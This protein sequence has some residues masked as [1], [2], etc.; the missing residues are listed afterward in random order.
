[1]KSPYFPD[2]QSLT[3]GSDSSIR[4][5]S[6]VPGRTNF[7]LA[8]LKADVTLVYSGSGGLFTVPAVQVGAGQ[9]VHKGDISYYV[10]KQRPKQ[11]LLGVD[12]LFFHLCGSNFL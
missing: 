1:M 4:Q 11:H 10:P 5:Y 8:W 3:V 9:Q 12:S 7:G 2:P 6:S